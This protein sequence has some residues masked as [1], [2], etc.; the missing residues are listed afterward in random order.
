M[1]KIGRKKVW[2]YPKAF[3]LKM[4][5]LVLDQDMPIQ[6]LSNRYGVAKWT[7]YRWL[8]AYSN[9]RLS[10]MSKK[11]PDK[12]SKET[13]SLEAEL[14]ALKEELRIERLRVESYKE[15]LKQAEHHFKIRIE[16]KSGSKQFTK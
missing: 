1:K 11:G 3:R 6:E 16:K 14:E 8:D 4:I 9:N 10:S 12:Q 15:L 2:K 5:N 7:I 13:S